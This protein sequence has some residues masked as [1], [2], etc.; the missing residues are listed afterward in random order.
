MLFKIYNILNKKQKK[1]FFIQIILMLISM[2]F[3]TIGIGILLPA[4][5]IMSNDKLIYSNPQIV[6]YLHKLNIYNTRELIIFIFCL[7]LIIN[8][9]KM[10]FIVFNSC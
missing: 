4:L 6:F 10:F 8:V 3:E 7:I 1:S 9:I 2:F 5:S